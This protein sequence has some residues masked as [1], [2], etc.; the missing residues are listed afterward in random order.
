LRVVLIGT[1]FEVRVWQALLRVPLGRATTYSDIASRIGKP[2]A[3]RAVGAAVGT[4]EVAEVGQARVRRVVD[5]HHTR[6]VRIVPDL[7]EAP[8]R[9]AIGEVGGV[10]G[11]GSGTRWPDSAGHGVVVAG[12]T[13]DGTEAPGR[14][15]GRGRLGL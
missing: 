11:R 2:S 12:P 1:D 14:A 7:I 3:S 13:I 6:H 15:R 4:R 5:R 8:G 9:A 10:T